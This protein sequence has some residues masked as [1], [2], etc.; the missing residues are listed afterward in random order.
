M[1][2]TGKNIIGGGLSGD[3]KTTF[4]AVNP[5]TGE[6]IAPKFNEATVEEI[7]AAIDKATE[8]FQTYRN[9]SGEEKA[10]FLETIADEILSLGDDLIQRCMK[11]SGLPEARLVGER[12]RTMSQLKLFAQVLREGSWVD[13]RIDYADPDRKPLPK[14]DIRSMLR[15]LGPV[16]IFGASNFP[17]AFSVAGGDTASALAAGC[18]VVVKGHPAHPGTSE[19]VGMA[20]RAAVKKC[21]MP[22]GTFSLVHGASIEVGQTIV[23]H[24]SIKAIGFTGSFRGGKSLFDEAAKREEP[25]PVYAEMGS[26]NPVFILPRALKAKKESI[27]QDLSASVNL[28]VG[29]FCTNPG[30]VFLEASDEEVHFRTLLAEKMGASD[31]GVMLTKGIR[32]SYNT[33]IENLTKVKGVRVLAEGKKETSACYGSS[34]LLHASANTFLE[35]PVLQEEVFGPS[36]VAVTADSKS[37]LMAAAKKLHGHLTITIH[38]TEEDL[39]EHKDLIELLEQKAGRL[40]INGYPTGV[41]VCH[42]MVH[43]GPFPATTDSRTTSVGTG[44]IFRFARPVCYQ[45]YPQS[46]LPEELKNEN[47]LN[48]MRLVDGNY[49]RA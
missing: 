22:E 4:F 36:T 24:P 48:I 28:G 23:R 31:P 8:A 13:A 44:A 47:P 30:L 12:G 33:G 21:N 16:G 42:A 45:N 49:K 40:T 5:A 29:Q 37:E 26:T 41:E 2:L 38:G 43:G 6:N 7:N 9:K 15:P 46:L 27:A 19:M 11:E 1:E 32:D 10:I 18:T 34:Y 35:E 17:L 25:I 20:I 39:E 14:A 3:G